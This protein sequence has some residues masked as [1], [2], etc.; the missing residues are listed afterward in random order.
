MPYVTCL[1]PVAVKMKEVILPSAMLFYM[2]LNI[3]VIFRELSGTFNDE[4]IFTIAKTSD[5]LVMVGNSVK[6]LV[7]S[8]RVMF[9][10]CFVKVDRFD[11][12]ILVG[13]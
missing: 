7:A 8:C 3:A 9:V 5:G 2:K 1:A 4:C 12:E 10:L 6:G 11:R 13:G